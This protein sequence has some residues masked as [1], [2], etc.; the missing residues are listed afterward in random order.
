MEPALCVLCLKGVNVKGSSSTPW[1]QDIIGLCQLLTPQLDPLDDDIANVEDESCDLCSFCWDLI[2]E[3]KMIQ[4]QIAQLQVQT[5][6]RIVLVRNRILDS[7]PKF[8]QHQTLDEG[9]MQRLRSIRDIL[10]RLSG[11]GQF[12]IMCESCE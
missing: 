7:V 8:K 5:A 2:Y 9:E 11:A 12:R 10:V 6:K 4:E 3:M 1:R